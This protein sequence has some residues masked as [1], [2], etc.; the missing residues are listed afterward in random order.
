MLR[1][2]GLYQGESVE[3]KL[4]SADELIKFFEL[5]ISGETAVFE[6]DKGSPG[7]ITVNQADG[8]ERF[9]N[10]TI[11]CTVQGMYQG[12]SYFIRYYDTAVRNPN[13]DDMVY[14]PKKIRFN[15]KQKAFDLRMEK[16]QAVLFALSKMCGDSPFHTTRDV[17]HYRLVNFQARAA[18][19]L[20][21]Q[22]MY[23]EVRN[24]IL[25][26]SDQKSM[27]IA[28]AIRVKGEQVSYDQTFT[29]VEAKAGLLALATRYPVQ[30]AEAY[31]S[32]QTLIAGIAREAIDNKKIRAKIIGAGNH[33]WMYNDSGMEICR[34]PPG[35]DNFTALVTHISDPGIFQAFAN[36]VGAND[37]IDSSAKVGEYVANVAADNLVDQ[38]INKGVVVYD[39]QANKV[40]LGSNFQFDPDSRALLS[41]KDGENWREALH[42]LGQVQMNR[43]KKAL[44]ETV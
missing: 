31:N 34:V 40:Y 10:R 43:L 2:T 21:Y 33:M 24:A 16:E 1:I 3:D 30:F 36:M 26:D 18:A 42:S 4:V 38:A 5:P 29:G 11:Q 25:N 23:Q 20:R 13:T 12:N 17:S 32:P 37:A 27:R 8:Q 28:K 19:N 41:L 9:G 44:E 22:Q 7:V 6:L 35:M 15:G 14:T 39:S